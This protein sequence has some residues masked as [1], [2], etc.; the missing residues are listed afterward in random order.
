VLQVCVIHDYDVII[1]HD[2]RKLMFIYLDDTLTVA[3]HT[4][5]DTIEYTPKFIALLTN[6]I[7][8]LEASN[9]WSLSEGNPPARWWNASTLILR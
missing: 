6:L 4:Q 1:Y 9:Y 3:S 5:A 7:V 2:H 8:A